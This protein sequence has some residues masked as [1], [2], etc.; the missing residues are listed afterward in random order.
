MINY[1]II[2]LCTAAFIAQLVSEE[3]GGR[4][5][6]RFGMVPARLSNADADPVIN[7]R[8]RIQTPLGIEVR[9][10]TRELAPSP[11]PAWMTLITC[12]FLHGGWM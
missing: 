6:E 10:I 11:I 3:R 8:V 12:M 5:A 9:T 7:E 4:I 2:G 1:L